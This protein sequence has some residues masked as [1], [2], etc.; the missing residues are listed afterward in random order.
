MKI[1]GGP[2][3]Q[4]LASRVARELN[5]KPVVCEF[6]KFPDGEQY[7]RILD[8]DIEN[9]R[10]TIIQCTYTDSDLISLLQLIDAC[11]D[12]KQINVVIPYLGYSRQDKKFKNGE[13]ISARAITRTLTADNVFTVNVHEKSILEYIDAN[14]TTD[15]E[16]S[17]LMGNHIESLDLKNP[18]IVAPDS[19]AIY[20]A[21]NASSKTGIEYDYLE[22]E[23][24]S[25]DEVSIKTKNM[26]ITGRDVVLIDDMIATGGTMAESI[27]ILKS[28]GANDVYLA[29]VHPVLAKNAVLRLFNAGV[30]DIISTDT[31]EKAE[32]AVSV[33]PLIA[34]S[35]NKI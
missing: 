15:L 11:E 10:V 17:Y 13:A 8:G 9:E 31:I 2:A 19:G 32:S 30:R 26:D 27:K 23:R 24:I 18:L 22:K 12:A 20:L 1:I 25:G 4:L 35:L 21:E 3:S 7:I 28:Q 5:D 6:D 16:A 33:A 34:D 14:N 29:C